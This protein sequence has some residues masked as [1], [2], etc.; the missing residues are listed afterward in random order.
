VDPQQRFAYVAE[1]HKRGKLSDY[2]VDLRRG[3]GSVYHASLSGRVVCPASAP[4]ERFELI[5]QRR[6]SG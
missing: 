1:L 2:R 5:E 6:V 4:M 3:D